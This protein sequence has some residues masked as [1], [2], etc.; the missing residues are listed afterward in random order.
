MASAFNKSEEGLKEY[1]KADLPYEDTID[2]HQHEEFEKLCNNSIHKDER[3][4]QIYK[5]I[6][7]RTP[8]SG[9]CI[10]YSIMERCQ[11]NWG[12]PIR[13]SRT[14]VGMYPI[15]V[16]QYGGRLNPSTG[17]PERYVV[18]LIEVKTGFSIKRSKAAFEKLESMVDPQTTKCYVKQGNSMRYVES[19]EDLRDGV[20]FDELMQFGKSARRD[21]EERKAVRDAQRQAAEDEQ[22]A[23]EDAKRIAEEAKDMK[24]QESAKETL[25]EIGETVPSEPE[26][27]KTPSKGRPASRR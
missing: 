4:A 19:W 12:S 10:V 18:G 2:D 27:E 21:F 5:I 23:I 11:D 1:K 24:E 22:K 3:T 15:P 26:E 20:P 6:L 17:A 7:Y 16:V 14:R 8:E 13:S 9:E 25:K